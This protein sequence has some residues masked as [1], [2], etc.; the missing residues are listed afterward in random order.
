MNTKGSW[1]RAQ[2]LCAMLLLCG[3]AVSSAARV[4]LYMSEANNVLDLSW[5]N[6]PSN[7]ES[8]LRSFGFDLSVAVDRQPRLTGT[9]AYVIPAQHGSAFYSSAE[10][11][12]AVSKFVENGG[13]VVLLGGKADADRDFVAKALG[14]QGSWSVCKHAGCNSKSSQGVPLLAEQA[15]S[16]FSSKAQDAWPASLEDAKTISFNT[17]CRHEDV[18]AFTIPLYTAAGDEM[19]VAAQAFGKA[20]VSGAVV[21]LGYSWK[22]GAKARWGELLEKLVSDF[23]AGAYV[24]PAQ[25]NA[26]EH[27][28]A[29]DSV[30]ESAADV[31]DEAAEVVVEDFVVT[32]QNQTIGDQDPADLQK[33]Q[34]AINSL[35]DDIQNTYAKALG[36][37]ATAIVVRGFLFVYRNGTVIT[38]M[39]DTTPAKRRRMALENVAKVYDRS[40]VADMFGSGSG[41]TG[42]IHEGSYAANE[43]EIMEMLD[44][45]AALPALLYRKLNEMSR[46]DLQQDDYYIQVLVSI[47]QF[48]EPVVWY[49]DPNFSSLVSNLSPLNLINPFKPSCPLKCEGCP[50]TWRASD[51]MTVVPLFFR[52]PVQ[53]SRIFIKQVR[54]SG[55]VKVQFIKWTG[56][57]SNGNYAP[58]LGRVIYNVTKDTTKCQSVLAIRVGPKKS[59]VNMA[60][61]TGGSQSN[62][63][64]KLKDKVIGGVVITMQRPAGSGPNYG[65]FVEY[66]RFQGRAVYPLDSS[67]YTQFGRKKL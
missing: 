19:K 18:E 33:N 53:I 21:V 65:P 47:V 10:D 66:V 25:G 2:G 37:N 52:D 35:V 6:G 48:I 12:S 5:D 42:L 15:S 26:D 24:V 22:E 3:L 11:M 30:L 56:S 31:A 44:A 29:V 13:L 58:D 67:I 34:T 57:P 40:E 20:G 7:L 4:S 50:Y 63:Q 27:P 9:D 51:D 45:E 64:G 59:G 60:V 23:A 36:V 38:I 55:V 17:W 62:I 8:Q 16:F 46:R 41:V 14:Y 39:V 54:N 28:E 43:D 49:N 1:A 32:Y 61:P